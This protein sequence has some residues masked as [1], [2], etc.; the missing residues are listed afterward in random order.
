MTRARKKAVEEREAAEAVKAMK[1]K[2]KAAKK[3]LARE[4]MA[5]KEA[6]AEAKKAIG[7][8]MYS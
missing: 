6:V 2:E 7:D 1:P 5:V 8:S 4:K 3:A